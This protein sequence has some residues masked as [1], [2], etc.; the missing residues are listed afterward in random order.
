MTHY[1][2]RCQATKADGT[3]CGAPEALVNN[4]T[5]FCPSHGPG[6]AEHLAEAGRKG[7][8]ATARKFKLGGL[9]PDD[10]P[11]LDRP[12]AAE[13]WLETIGRAVATGRLGH[14]EA[15][16]AVG[17]VRQWLKANE[18]GAVAERLEELKASVE[19]LGK[20]GGSSRGLKAL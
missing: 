18:A 15:R 1:Y 6:A 16:S 8:A 5:G 7:A 9:D 13:Q 17:A 3:P 19:R 4:K 14:N 2:R 12:Q 20:E 10:L 11:P